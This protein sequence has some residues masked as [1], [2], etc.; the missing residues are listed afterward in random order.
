MFLSCPKFSFEAKSK[1]DLKELLT[2][3]DNGVRD[4]DSNRHAVSNL[5]PHRDEPP[6]DIFENLKVPHEDIENEENDGRSDE[7]TTYACL[8]CKY[9][10]DEESILRAHVNSVHENIIW[11][12]DRC[13]FTSSFEQMLNIHI[14]KNH[15]PQKAMKK[16]PCLACD[17]MFTTERY[18]R[19]HVE[20]VHG[21]KESCQYCGDKFSKAFLKRHIKFMHK[22]FKL[23]C[24]ECD[25]IFWDKKKLRRHMVIDHDHSIDQEFVKGSE[26]RTCKLCDKLFKEAKNL[27]VHMETVHWGLKKHSCNECGQNFGQKSSLKRHILLKHKGFFY[28][29]YI[30][31][32]GWGDGERS[33]MS[34][35]I[36][37]VHNKSQV[38]W[39]CALNHVQVHLKN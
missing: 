14:S 28:K 31:K 23:R 19:S 27:M 6:L 9:T 2:T 25:F 11:R 33:K 36:N 15:N 8:K 26:E 18:A 35:H 4:S 30:D 16:F 7:M 37:K 17:K 38:E 12:C 3:I 20:F 10:A 32:C 39:I 21:S 29:C 24:S 22:G 34:K 13:P 5:V 1:D